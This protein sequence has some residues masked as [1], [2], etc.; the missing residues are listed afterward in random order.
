MSIFKKKLLLFQIGLLGLAIILLNIFDVDMVDGRSMEPTYKDRELLLSS[1]IFKTIDP[2]DV[3][4]FKEQG[5]VLIKRVWYISRQHL[6]YVLGDNLDNSIDSRDFGGIERS[7]I[8][9]KVLF[10]KPAPPVYKRNILPSSNWQDIG[11]WYLGLGFESL[12]E[13]QW[14][15]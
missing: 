1:Q 2:G 11:F 12:G 14:I 4:V 10:P 9:S 6:I 7:Q 8:V 15:Q 3:I 13:N 5:E